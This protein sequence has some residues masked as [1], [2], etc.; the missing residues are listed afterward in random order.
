MTNPAEIVTVTSMDGIPIV[1]LPDRRM[2]TSGKALAQ[3]ILAQANGGS[4]PPATK[5]Q[6]ARAVGAAVTHRSYIADPDNANANGEVMRDEMAKLRDLVRPE[7]GMSPADVADRI[8]QVAGMARQQAENLPTPDTTAANGPAEAIKGAQLITR[9]STGSG[10]NWTPGTGA[11]VFRD[12]IR[13]HYTEE[14]HPAR[15]LWSTLAKLM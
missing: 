11:R 5:E 10:D 15:K 3:A 2:T 12:L 9:E 7:S 1:T 6:V 4:L 14:F 8:A 13:T